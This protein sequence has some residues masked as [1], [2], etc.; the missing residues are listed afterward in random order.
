M[1]TEKAIKDHVWCEMLWRDVDGNPKRYKD[2]RRGGDDTLTQIHSALTT[3][4]PNKKAIL[5][6]LKNGRVALPFQD[7]FWVVILAEA[8]QLLLTLNSVRVEKIGE[9]SWTV[10]AVRERNRKPRTQDLLD[11][12]EMVRRAVARDLQETFPRQ[13][14]SVESVYEEGEKYVTMSPTDAELREADAFFEVIRSAADGE[15]PHV[16][17]TDRCEVCWW[18]A[19]PARVPDKGAV[20]TGRPRTISL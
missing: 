20:A 18:K 2:D 16:A 19:C 7:Q 13:I 3:G 5:E 14:V 11:A 17:R 12:E 8:S 9:G 10:T 4:S 1:L 6:K 15:K